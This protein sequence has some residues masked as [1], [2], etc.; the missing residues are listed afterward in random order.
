MVRNRAAAPEQ[1][2]AEAVADAL[3]ESHPYEL[4]APNEKDLN[5]IDLD[6][7]LAVYRRRFASAK[8]MTF[9][10]VGDFDPAV[11]DVQKTARRYLDKDNYVQVVLVPEAKLKT[12]GK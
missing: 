2:F 10:V 11:A 9:I 7:S 8:G 12:A 6:R 4:R 1:R 5:K 3:Y